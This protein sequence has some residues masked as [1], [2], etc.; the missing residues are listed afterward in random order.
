[1]SGTTTGDEPALAPPDGFDAVAYVSSSLARVRTWEVS[2]A[3]PPRRARG[4][5]HPAT[6]A[7][8]LEEEEGV[9]VLRMRVESLEWMASLFAGLGCTFTVRRPDELRASVREL[10]GPPRDR[11]G[12]LGG[13]G[14]RA[15]GDLLAAAAVRLDEP[16]RQLG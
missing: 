13:P 5:A 8:E 7:G 14:R 10:L 16:C 3:R 4:R 1:M 2:G 12:S 15:C 9:T 6:L 11:Q